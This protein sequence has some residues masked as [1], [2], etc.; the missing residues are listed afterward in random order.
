MASLEYYQRIYIIAAN[1]DINAIMCEWEMGEREAAT[2]TANK[3]IYM[4]TWLE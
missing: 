2:C 1:N 3:H 4:Q